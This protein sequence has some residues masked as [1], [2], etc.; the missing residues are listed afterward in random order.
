[1]R[2]GEGNLNRLQIKGEWHVKRG[3]ALQVEDAPEL[4]APLHPSML[5]TEASWEDRAQ[6]SRMSA[7]DFTE[8]LLLDV[9]HA[10]WLQKHPHVEVVASLHQDKLHGDAEATLRRL[11]KDRVLSRLH[12]EA[13]VLN[14]EASRGRVKSDWVEPEAL[15]WAAWRALPPGEK[16]EIAREAVLGFTT[17][18]HDAASMDPRGD[19]GDPMEP[20]RHR[21]H[22]LLWEALDDERSSLAPGDPVLREL[23]VW[24]SS[25]QTYLARR[26]PF[27]YGDVPAPWEA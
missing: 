12:A 10:M 23:E 24:K 22:P 7:R 15:F 18:V 5:T 26:P 19:R 8:A 17:R 13:K 11:K 2:Y 25:R 1:M 27:S 4:D 14:L 16:A 3:D 9:H 21:V 20:H 6:I